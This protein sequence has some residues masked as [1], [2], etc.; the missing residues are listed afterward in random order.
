[1]TENAPVASLPMY[2]WPEVAW[3]N[4]ALWQAISDRL[5]RAGV[6]APAALE[7]ARPLHD[8][9]RDPGL[10]L[11]QTCGYPFAISLKGKVRLVATPVYAVEGCDGP[12]YSSAI[13]M[14]RDESVGRLSDCL[15]RRF[16]FNSRDS[17]S[18]HVAL[19]VAMREAGIDPGE[20]TWVETGAHRASIRAVADG[21]AD[22]AAIDAVTWSFAAQYERPAAERLRVIG[23]TPL[24]P[25]LPL[26]A[27]S[28]RS[29][30]DAL[31]SALNDA[32]ADPD[33]AA[34]RTALRIAGL[35]SI[36]TGEY[37]ALAALPA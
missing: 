30:E 16:A 14:R 25:G 33:T 11:S 1:L 2:D 12:R 8:V 27:S 4:D 5:R 28:E 29:D 37:E 35:S 10:V 9:W 13:V 34:A 19:A 26:I 15:G 20:A 31:R 22:I 23:W 17:L 32:V 36:G 6:A 7:R 3:A 24:R 18:G 21:V